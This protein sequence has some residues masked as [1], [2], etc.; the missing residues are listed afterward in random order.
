MKKTYFLLLLLLP[1][2]TYSQT[3]CENNLSN[4]FPC[5]DYDLMD[6]FDKT[7]LSNE[8]GS[9]IWG[10]TDSL[11]GSEYALMTFEDKTCFI[12]ITDPVNPVYLGFLNTNAGVNYW[13]D[14]KVYQNHA[15]I[16]ADNVGTHGMQVFDLTRLRNVANPPENFTADTVLTNG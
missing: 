7:Q 4:G 5:D 6:H 14:V 9:D 11:D 15:Y 1:I 10:W 12:N 13:R 2:I 3:P 16:V 8:D